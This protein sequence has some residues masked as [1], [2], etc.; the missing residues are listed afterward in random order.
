MK[1][2]LALLPLLATAAADDPLAGLTPGQPVNCI[3]ATNV[4]SPEILGPTS[5]L[6]RQSQN[7]TWQ[8]APQR[9]CSPLNVR[10]RLVVRPSRDRY[11]CSGDKFYV[12]TRDSHL[13]SATCSFGAFTPYERPA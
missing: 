12:F 10:S 8:V 5:I 2:L 7:R 11:L 1:A 13:P 3:P 6:Y 4:L 9:T